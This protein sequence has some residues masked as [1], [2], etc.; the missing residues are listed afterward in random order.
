MAR[1]QDDFDTAVN[2]EW[3]EQNPIPDIYPRYTNFTK[4]DEELEQLKIGM[5]KDESN[6][7]IHSLFR[8][9]SE[10]DEG[11]VMDYIGEKVRKIMECESKQDLCNHLLR[12]IVKGQYQIFHVCH[13][14]TERNPLFQIPHFSVGG[15]SLP[16]MSYYTERTELRE[17]LLEMIGKQLGMFD[18]SPA[19]LD[20]IWDMETLLAT[21]H[22]TKAEKREPLKTYHPTT[23]QAV[24]TKMSPYF[25]EIPTIFPEDYHDIT[26]NNH[27]ILDGLKR[28][29]DEFSLDQLK[30]WY[31]WKTV[32]GSVGYTTNQLYQNNFDFYNTLLNG[33]QTPKSIEKRGAIMIEGFVEDLFTQHYLEHHVDDD[34][35]ANFSGFVEDIRHALYEKMKKATWM[36][37]KTREKALDKLHSMTLKVVGPSKFRDYSRLHKTYSNFLEFVD[38]YYLWDWEV[39]EVEEKM[40]QLRDPETWLMSSMTINAY[41]H[42]LYNEIVFPAGI[43]QPPFYGSE[44]SLA[45][46]L[47]GIGA[48]IAHEMTHGFDDQGSRFDKNGYLYNWW[49]KETRENY[50]NII[51]KM[52]EHFNSLIHE[53]KPVN[54]KLTQGENL[55]DI[56]GLRTAMSLCKTD[57]DKKECMLSWA[58]IWRANVRREYAQQMIVLDPH[59]P[60]RLRV[61]GILQHIDDFYRIFDVKEGDGMYLTPEKRCAIWNE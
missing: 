9:Y 7:F 19:S 32:R 12:N 27:H 50:E 4:L 5:C 10:Q 30:V 57:D 45:Q 16:D 3:K 14:G 8:L 28:V 24:V 55:A 54:G 53:D 18:V 42:P 59:S 39:L 56:G 58:R 48:V 47:G 29:I 1:F 43:L 26:L 38:E 13:S 31:A 35:K 21:Y 52:E 17:P 15:L 11:S 2:A 23:V 41:Y 33:I 6:E 22:Y 34:L 20:F 46:N 49:S 61:N 36:C 25:D 60:P 51:V 37:E 40:Y 44:Q